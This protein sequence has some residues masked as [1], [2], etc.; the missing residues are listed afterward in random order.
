MFGGLRPTGLV[1]SDTLAL[2]G[3]PRCGNSDKDGSKM[4]KKRYKTSRRGK[5][6]KKESNF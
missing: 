5:T 2:L 4:R 6:K 1:D 3:A